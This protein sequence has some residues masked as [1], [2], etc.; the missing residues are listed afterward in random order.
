VTA[1]APFPGTCPRW[2]TGVMFALLG[3]GS[4]LEA[5][6]IRG[7]VVD[8]ETGE[9]VAVAMVVLLDDAG[10]RA[11]RFVTDPNGAFHFRSVAAGRYRVRIERIGY[12]DYTSDAIDVGPGA[13]DFQGTEETIRVWTAS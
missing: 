4:S 8:G 9:P 6:G 5:Q 3:M 1:S 2:L 13:T 12:R 11:A 7:T 10:E